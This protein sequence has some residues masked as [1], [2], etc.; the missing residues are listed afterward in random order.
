MQISYVNLTSKASAPRVWRTAG[1]RHAFLSR[2]ACVP[3]QTHLPDLYVL[4]L[5]IPTRSV[6]ATASARHMVESQ[7]PSVLQNRIQDK[8][9]KSITYSYGTSFSYRDPAHACYCESCYL[10]HFKMLHQ[11]YSFRE[12]KKII[13]AL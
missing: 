8:A 11:N 7:M 2:A 4:H 1:H 9:V 3:Q 10:N 6:C 12:K 5:R 13:A